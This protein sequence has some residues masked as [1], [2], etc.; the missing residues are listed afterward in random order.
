MTTKFVEVTLSHKYRE[1]ISD[2]TMSGGPM[3]FMKNA[4]FRLFGKKVNLKWVGILFAFATVLSS[5]GTGNLPQINSI[6]NSMLASFGIDKMITGGVLSILLG[7]VIIGGIKRIA[8]ITEKLV[9]FMA[10]IYILGAFSVIIFNYQNIIPSFI[11]IFSE[12]FSGSAAVGGFLG[13][14]VSYAI[15]R[16]VNRGLY[17]NEAGQ[18]SAPIAHASAKTNEPVSEGLVAILEP[19]I[20]TI[21]IC[22]ITGL[23]L[24][25]SGVWSEKHHN[26]FAQ[27]DLIFLDRVYM[28]Q[29]QDDI[30]I[31]FDYLNGNSSINKFNG[32]A[33]VENGLLLNSISIIHARSIAEDVIIYHNNKNQFTG[34]INIIDGK[35]QDDLI[36]EGK[37]LVHSAPLTAMAFDKGFLGNYGN[38]IVSIGLLLFAFST[39]I[40]WSYYG[41]R[42]MTYLFGTGSVVYYRIVYVIGFFIASFADTTVIWNV[43]L[44]TIALMT[45]PNLIGLLWLRKE[46]RSTVKDYWINFKKEWPNENTPE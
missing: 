1:K 32:E 43:S 4:D 8:K 39:A 20:D 45:I 29:N 2:G 25:S 14:S 38:Y 36:V 19:F 37:S 34:K 24:L 12:L 5:F 6:S 21:I 41:D 33:D 46:V 28:E 40:A 17:S 27:A 7:A 18:G 31:L 30:K 15:S 16:G 10:V 42:A 13:A 35:I 3:Y 26:T 44:I 23:V 9:P 22:T 11:S